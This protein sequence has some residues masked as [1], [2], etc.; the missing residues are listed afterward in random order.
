MFINKFNSFLFRLEKRKKAK[1][2][3]LESIRS[4]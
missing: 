4:K 1:N 3:Y 2:Y